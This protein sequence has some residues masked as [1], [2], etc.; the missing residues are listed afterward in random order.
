MCYI[1]RLQDKT[2]R[3]V[4]DKA[5]ML[6]IDILQLQHMIYP[7]MAQFTAISA[8]DQVTELPIDFSALE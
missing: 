3:E 1:D 6:Y 4:Y 5:I 7:D 2:C 8:G